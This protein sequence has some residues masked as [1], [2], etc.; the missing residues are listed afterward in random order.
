MAKKKLSA[1][2]RLDNI[3]KAFKAAF[4]RK[5]YSQP[6]YLSPADKPVV[7]G[8]ES[9]EIVYAKNQPEYLPLRTLRS[10]DVY[11]VVL[12]RWSLTAEQRDAILNGADVFLELSTYGQPLQPI[13]MYVAD[14]LD[15]EQMRAELNLP[16]EPESSMLLK[17][18]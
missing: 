3:G 17:L 11:R 2:D 13:R 4:N 15:T 8:L 5:P 7:A 16:C 12:S 1:K 18:A 10:N 9:H 14:Q 6:S